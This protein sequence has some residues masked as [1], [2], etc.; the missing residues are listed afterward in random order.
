[1]ILD[2]FGFALTLLCDWS[3]KIA[4]LAQPIKYKTKT[5]SNSVTRVFPR[6]KLA[7]CFYHEF[8]LAN[9]D[10]SLWSNR[11]LWLLWIWFS[12]TQSK[13]ASSLLLLLFL[14]LLHRK[15]GLI[16][17]VLLRLIM[18]ITFKMLRFSMNDADNGIV[19]VVRRCCYCLHSDQEIKML[20]N[21]T[22]SDERLVI[23]S[24]KFVWKGKL[25]VRSQCSWFVNCWNSLLEQQILSY[26]PSSP[27]C[28]S[29]RKPQ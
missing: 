23:E 14:F 4:P 7:G 12:I 11:Y 13:I 28:A 17:L 19:S 27:A 20:G 16:F 9:D 2:C 29:R 18:L 3:R 6:F 10:V 21:Y 15:R 8:S 1:M 26:D 25:R 22:V 24:S 5:N